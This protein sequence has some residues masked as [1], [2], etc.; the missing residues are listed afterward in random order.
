MA[1]YDDINTVAAN[2]GFQP[3]CSYALTAAAASVLTE[4]AATANHQVRVDYARKVIAGQALTGLQ[5]ALAL[6][7]ISSLNS[8]LAVATT[9]DFGMT[10]AQIQTA[11]TN[12]FNALA[13][14]ST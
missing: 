10:D 11:A 4:S 8:T 7:T 5:L 1:S 6:L 2:A 3:R 14:V 13:G 12:A 9:P